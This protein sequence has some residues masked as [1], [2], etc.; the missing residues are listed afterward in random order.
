[1]EEVNLSLNDQNEAIVSL[2]T[3]HKCSDMY[4]GLYVNKTV[5]NNMKEQLLKSV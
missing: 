4:L 3:V 2:L 5:N 1:M